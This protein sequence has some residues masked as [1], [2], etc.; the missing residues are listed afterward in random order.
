MF[1]VNNNQSL[2]MSFLLFISSNEPGNLWVLNDQTTWKWKICLLFYY[3]IY[4]ILMQG[5]MDH[6][7][8]AILTIT[9]TVGYLMQ[10]NTSMEKNRKTFFS[11]YI[12]QCQNSCTPFHSCHILLALWHKRYAIISFTLRYFSIWFRLTISSHRLASPQFHCRGDFT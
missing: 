7:F 3:N 6:R 5:L 10:L 2:T 11:N 4:L 9:L 8:C 12:I 1:S